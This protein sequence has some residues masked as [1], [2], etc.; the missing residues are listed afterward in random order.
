MWRVRNIPLEHY[1]AISRAMAGEMDFRQVLV[2][3][4][5]EVKAK[6]L[7]YDHMDIALIVPGREDLLVAVEVGMETLWSRGGVRRPV[8]QSPI[9]SLLEGEVP[10]LLTGDAWTDDRFHFEGA[11]DGPIFEA[12]LH[13]R[14]HV[15]L[16]VHGRVHGSLNISSHQR[17]VYDL[18]DVAVARNIADLISPYLF[19]LS[20]GE[21][22]RA[23][24]LAEGAARGREESLRLGA[25]RLTEALEAER[26]RLGME[27]HDQTLADLSA[28]YRQVNRLASRAG[29]EAAK[30]GQ[31]AESIAR[32]MAELRGIIENAKPGVLDLFGLTQAIE[33]QLARAVAGAGRHIETTLMDATGGLIEAAPESVRIAI[34]RIVQEAVTN[35][36]RHSGCRRISVRLSPRSGGGARI[37]IIN[38]GARPRPGWRQ[39]TG[40]IENI[41][42]RAALMS[43]QVSFR[44]APEGGVTIT[45][46]VPARVI[47]G[48]DV[49]GG[50]ET[51]AA[52]PQTFAAAA[53]GTAQ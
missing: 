17:D 49:T 6:F 34:F 14:I 5:E 3:I 40:G 35:A 13:A 15:P 47:S 29:P 46:D 7:D 23:A 42:V 30:L 50:A 16:T 22:A 8:A 52:P 53:G 27:L 41:R 21:E 45:L 31:I 38:D 11:L 48:A 33:A 18:N 39:S 51:G 1:L 37:E 10:Y 25:R 28:I 19:A 4:A 24:A 44:E 20:M 32:C 43:S 26:R 36:V 2:R 9:R 12:N